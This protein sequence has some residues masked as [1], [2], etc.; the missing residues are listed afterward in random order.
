MLN[1]LRNGFEN[2]N[3]SIYPGASVSNGKQINDILQLD[4]LVIIASDPSSMRDY[5][6]LNLFNIEYMQLFAEKKEFCAFSFI[7]SIYSC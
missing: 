7:D 3:I 5:L 4:D 1:D 2:N 6:A